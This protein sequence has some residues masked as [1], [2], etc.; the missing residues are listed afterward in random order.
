M[1]I[2]H[3]ID[4]AVYLGQRV[5]VMTLAARPHQE[6]R[7]HPARTPAAATTDLRSDPRS[8][9]YRHEIWTLLRDEVHQGPAR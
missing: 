1:F 3:G 5:A 2:T 7:R 4:E 8:R 6:D 9:E